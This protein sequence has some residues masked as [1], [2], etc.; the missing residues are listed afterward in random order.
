MQTAA[1]KKKKKKAKQKNA[2][3]KL[4]SVLMIK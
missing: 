4:P 3:P 1:K 2:D